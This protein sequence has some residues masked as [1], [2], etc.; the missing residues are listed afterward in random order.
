MSHHHLY[1]GLNP[2]WSDHPELGYLL[3]LR[4]HNKWTITLNHAVC[5][6]EASQAASSLLYIYF[7]PSSWS[8]SN[9]TLLRL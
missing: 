1:T 6:D 7:F 5:L 8:T 4:N 9:V 2:L 3:T